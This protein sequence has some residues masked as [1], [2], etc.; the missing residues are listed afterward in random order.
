LGLDG[1]ITAYERKHGITLHVKQKE[2]LKT[3]VG[4]KISVITGGRARANHHR[5]TA[6]GA[7]PSAGRS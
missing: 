3:S 2:A 5:Q 6:S 7:E 1:Q 4:N